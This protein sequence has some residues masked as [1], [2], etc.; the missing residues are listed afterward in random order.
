MVDPRE[1]ADEQ[2]Y[3]PIGFIQLT[4]F[5]KEGIKQEALKVLTGESIILKTASR[6]RD[7]GNAAVSLE[8][9]LKAVAGS[10]AFVA[11]DV[12]NLV[13][14]LLLLISKAINASHRDSS[15]ST[16]AKTHSGS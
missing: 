15:G 7:V 5:T 10:L 11:K 6:A 2:Q 1:S 14:D 16:S 13:A 4:Q 9:E 8:P 3:N 12:G